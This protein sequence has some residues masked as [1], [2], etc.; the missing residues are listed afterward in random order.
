LAPYTDWNELLDEAKR[1]FKKFYESVGEFSI[2]RVATRYINKLEIP[3]ITTIDFDDY[4]TASPKIPE[5]LPQFTGEFLSRNVIPCPDQ[6]AVLILT[7]SF[8]GPSIQT[9]IASVI[10]DIDAFVER[11]FPCNSEECWTTLTILRDLKDLAFFGA[12][13]D[14]TVELIK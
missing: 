11:E 7:Q 14:K 8:Q 5:S 4:L 1:L 13:T 10:I 2:V 3:V 12:I 9:K 6:S